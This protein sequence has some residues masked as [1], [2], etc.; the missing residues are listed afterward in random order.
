MKKNEIYTKS[1]QI[2]IHLLYLCLDVY[3]NAI[4]EFLVF[5]PQL[6]NFYTEKSASKFSN[7]TK[8]QDILFD[9]LNSCGLNA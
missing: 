1:I 2:A 5:R 4:H 8:V 3:I 9:F 7:K 6:Y